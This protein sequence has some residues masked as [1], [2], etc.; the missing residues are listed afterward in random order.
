MRSVAAALLGLLLTTSVGWAE[1][2]DVRVRRNANGDAVVVIGDLRGRALPPALITG[3]TFLVAWH[4]REAPAVPIT[5]GGVG[6]I[7]D[8]VIVGVPMSGFDV[9]ED[10]DSATVRV[11]VVP[12]VH[13]GQPRMA[14]AR[15]DLERMSD[16][17]RVRSVAVE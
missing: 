11:I 2:Y 4:L 17:W 1:D 10:G 12:L 8:Q 15:L 6:A 5:I 14:K 7:L 9:V 13:N 3:L 16:R